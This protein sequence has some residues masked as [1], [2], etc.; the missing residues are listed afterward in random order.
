MWPSVDERGLRRGLARRVV[1]PSGC[2]DGAPPRRSSWSARHLGLLIMACLV[3][4][5]GALIANWAVARL[6]VSSD[7]AGSVAF[8]A[9]W[10]ALYP[11]MRL[12]QLG[13]VLAGLAVVLVGVI[14]ASGLAR[15]EP[16]KLMFLTAVSMAVAAVPEGLPAVVTIA[17]ALLAQRMLKRKV[18]IRKL[19]AVETLPFWAEEGYKCL[20]RWRVR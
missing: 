16:L 14:F 1:S 8:C 11:W 9:A 12:D 13:R 10:I 15:G 18:V 19:L 5:A 6:G 20:R 3:A 7:V 2:G 4:A 17:L